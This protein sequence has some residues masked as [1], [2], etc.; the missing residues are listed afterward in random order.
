MPHDSTEE[1]CIACDL[2]HTI[3]D[4]SK[5]DHVTKWAH[6]EVAKHRLVYSL[7]RFKLPV[8]S[9]T[10]DE[11]NGIAFD[12]LADENKN[13]KGAKRLLTG[14]DHGLITLNID[15]ADDAMREMAR[16][17]MDEVYRTV[18]GHFSP[19]DRPLLLGAAGKRFRQVAGFPST[20][21]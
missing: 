9:K 2:N 7:L 17:Q 3:P 8:I 5:P 14:H 11:E 15:E 16:N 1:F 4:L 19:R 6:I 20:L 10:Q 18:L 12:F 13:K 21:W